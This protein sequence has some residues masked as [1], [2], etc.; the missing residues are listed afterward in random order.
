LT[1]VG[2]IGGLQAAHDVDSSATKIIGFMDLV[3]IPAI[4]INPRSYLSKRL[5][6]L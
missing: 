4:I 5:I 2:L 3:L 6:G 1:D